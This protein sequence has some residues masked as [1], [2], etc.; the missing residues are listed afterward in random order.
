MRGETLPFLERYDAS[1]LSL[2]DNPSCPSSKDVAIVRAD[3]GVIDGVLAQDDEIAIAPEITRNDAVERAG[4]TISAATREGMH[5]VRDQLHGAHKQAAANCGCDECA[6]HLNVLSKIG[7]D[8]GDGD[9]DTRAVVAEIVHAEIAKAM[10]SQLSPVIQ[11]VNALL[12]HDAGRSEAVQERATT[13]VASKE[14]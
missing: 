4:A 9:M 5:A 2:V 13:P 10:Q 6:D 12:A 11:R 1:E 14:S 3:G 8:D 7:K